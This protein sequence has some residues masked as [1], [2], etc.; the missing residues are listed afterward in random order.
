MMDGGNAWL[1]PLISGTSGWWRPLP[2]GQVRLLLEPEGHRQ[3][4]LSCHY[5]ALGSLLWQQNKSAAMLGP[6]EHCKSD[7]ADLA[8]TKVS[9]AW[10]CQRMF[11]SYVNAF[12]D[13]GVQLS[14]ILFLVILW[15]LTLQIDTVCLVCIVVGFF[16]LCFIYY[17]FTSWFT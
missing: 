12:P 1:P 2:G 11:D 13:W 3:P 5:M 14:L 9:C 10:V 16:E 17:S 4:S 8:C 15:V 6:N 7:R